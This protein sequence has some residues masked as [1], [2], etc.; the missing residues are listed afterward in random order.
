[1]LAVVWHRDRVLLVHRRRAPQAGR[2]GFPGGHVEPGEPLTQ[3]AVREL[4]EETGIRAVP[5]SALPAID[6]I[7]RAPDGAVRHHFVLVPVRLRYQGGQAKA[8][9]DAAAAAWFDP[10]A[11]PE[12]LCTDV[13]ELIAAS[14]PGGPPP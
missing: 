12:P 13:A 2:W 9:D 1:V 6:L 10:A 7:E 5:E 8:S 3:A 4:G 11:L 14:R